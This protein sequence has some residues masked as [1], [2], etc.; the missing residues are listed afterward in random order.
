MNR[1]TLSRN[2]YFQTVHPKHHLLLCTTHTCSGCSRIHSMS[3][4]GSSTP[5]QILCT[6]VN[7]G[8]LKQNINTYESVPFCAQSHG[9]S[10]NDSNYNNAH[11]CC[12][13]SRKTVQKDIG[14]SL[15]GD[16]ISSAQKFWCVRW[17]ESESDKQIPIGWASIC[18]H[19]RA[20]TVV[21]MM[22][23]VNAN[24]KVLDS[25]REQLLKRNCLLRRD[26][27][28]CCRSFVIFLRYILPPSSGSISEPRNKGTMEAAN[29]VVNMFI[30]N[31]S[32]LLQDYMVSHP[33]TRYLHSHHWPG[34][35]SESW[36]ERRL[37]YKMRMPTVYVHNEYRYIESC[38]LHHTRHD[39]DNLFIWTK[40][41]P[42]LASMFLF[43]SIKLTSEAVI[44]P[45]SFWPLS[46]SFSSSSILCTKR[47]PEIRG[48]EFVSAWQMGNLTI[49]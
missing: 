2:A 42:Y 31:I 30:R 21:V 33:R 28:Y 10:C 22:M 49:K 29:W 15:K 6:A 1:Q 39:I 27:V 3:F 8:N 25:R 41:K 37:R 5:V 47:K 34:T 13:L 11:I 23:L 9:R 24:C 38:R 40:T 46:N 7:R 14:V 16:E 17:Q 36:T 20:A 19:D 35:W 12:A 48:S 26:A 32:K 18:P 4:C 45:W 44:G 43:L